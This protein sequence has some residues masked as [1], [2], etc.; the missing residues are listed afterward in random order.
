MTST[1]TTSGTMSNASTEPRRLTEF[2]F[3]FYMAPAH[4]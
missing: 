2:P 4:R 3:W 1:Q